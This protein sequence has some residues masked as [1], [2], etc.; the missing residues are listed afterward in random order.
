MNPDF[1]TFKKDINWF[2]RPNDLVEFSDTK[3]HPDLSD[4]FKSTFP[5]LSRLIQKAR[6]LDFS[7]NSKPYR[8]LSW[9]NKYNISCGWLTRIESDDT[10]NF[11][12]VQEHELLLKEIGGIVES[13]HQ[14]E[15]A[16][17]NNQD[18]LFLKSAC[19]TGIGEWEEYYENL[20]EEESKEPIDYNDFICFALEAN[21]NMTMYEKNSGKVILFAHDHWFEDV[22]VF[23]NQPEYTFYTIQGVENFVDYVEKM[24]DEWSEDLL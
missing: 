11:Q 22:D 10:D 15:P 4:D 21:G 24:A 7:I 8:L 23:E 2:I 19:M 5:A 6:T 1:E 20:C 12:L 13:Y 9:T 3:P 16:L 18:Y 17:T 14:P